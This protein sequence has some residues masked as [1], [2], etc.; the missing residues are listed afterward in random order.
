MDFLRGMNQPQGI[1]A[2]WL[3]QLPPQT[4]ARLEV[5]AVRRY[6]GDSRAQG[7]LPEG[8]YLSAETAR[9]VVGDFVLMKVGNL[10]GAESPSLERTDPPRWVVP[11]ILT[12]PQAGRIGEVGT[13]RVNAQTGELEIGRC[14]YW[15]VTITFHSVVVVGVDR[16]QVFLH[17]PF[18]PQAPILVTRVDFESAWSEEFFRAAMI[19]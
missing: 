12:N 10:L 9:R 4:V 13:L 15:P 5:E 2:R 3:E 14:P 16:E 1:S 11:V 7:A 18:C 8:V 19:R 6:H 17:D